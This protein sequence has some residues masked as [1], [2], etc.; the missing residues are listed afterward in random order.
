MSIL[1]KITVVGGDP[2][3]TEFPTPVEVT[4]TISTLDSDASGRNQA[5]RMFRDVVADKRKVQVRWGA[6]TAA[7]CSTILNMIDDPTFDI[8][9]P[10]AHDGT[11]R[12]MTCYVGDRTTPAYRL[13]DGDWRWTGLSVSFIEV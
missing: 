3:Y 12:E 7:D 4:W 13:Y 9:F 10:D 11:L 1:A 8:R 6:L 5:G 2:V